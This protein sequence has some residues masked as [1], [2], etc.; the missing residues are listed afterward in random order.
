MKL[1]GQALRHSPIVLS[2]IFG[3]FVDMYGHR[4][5]FVGILWIIVDYRKPGKGMCHVLRTGH[6]QIYI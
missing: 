2:P 3:A 4:F 5:Y 1:A 6:T